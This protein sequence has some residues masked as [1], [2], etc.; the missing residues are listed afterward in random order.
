MNVPVMLSTIVAFEVVPNTRDV[1]MP[2]T[3]KDD[4]FVLLAQFPEVVPVHVC[5]DAG[6]M[7]NIRKIRTNKR[8]GR[9]YGRTKQFAVMLNRAS[10]NGFLER[11]DCNE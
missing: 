11:I 3:G 8:V 5:A 1:L 2:L 4:Q 10:K 6:P 7:A 9:L